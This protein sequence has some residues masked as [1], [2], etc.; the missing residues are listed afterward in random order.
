MIQSFALSTKELGLVPITKGKKEITE[1]FHA[2]KSR[3][4]TSDFFPPHR[5]FSL[6]SLL[7]LPFSPSLLS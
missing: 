3:E 7:P 1:E 2:G 6:P 4:Q 5:I